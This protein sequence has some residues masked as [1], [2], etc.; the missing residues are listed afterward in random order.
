MQLDQIRTSLPDKRWYEYAY[1]KFFNP[2]V[3][4]AQ[5]HPWNEWDYPEKDLVRFGH[6][7]AENLQYI[8]NQRVLDV[9]CHLGYLSLFCLHN[10]ST[11]LTGTNV[12]VFELEIAKE[13]CRLAGYTNA[14]F[15]NTNLYDQARMSQLYN[16]HDTV[17][18]AGIVY[19]I[20]NHYQLFEQITK[21]TAKNIIIE[22]EIYPSADPVVNWIVEST[23]PSTRSYSE[24]DH[25]LLVGVPSLSFLTKTLEFFNWQIAKADVF[26]FDTKTS[27]DRTY[28]RAVVVA[29]R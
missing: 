12:R 1:H 28:Q 27:A 9:A 24:T 19:H 5:W 7:I 26:E 8:Q 16:S 3:D 18:L 11:Q 2:T 13:I 23:A 10:G 4:Y 15:E 14:T 22:G 6:I 21:S 25:Q 20:N 17:L 29:T